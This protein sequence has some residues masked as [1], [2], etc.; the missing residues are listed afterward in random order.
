MITSFSNNLDVGLGSEDGSDYEDT[1]ENGSKLLYF[2]V[3][4]VFRS[5]EENAG[6]RE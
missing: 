4:S 1:I 5:R 3:V 6:T 2:Y